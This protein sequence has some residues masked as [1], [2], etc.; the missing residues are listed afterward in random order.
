[1]TQLTHSF[2]TLENQNFFQ[3]RADFELVFTL[4]QTL[5]EGCV[6]L[7]VLIYDGFLFQVLS[8]LK[9]F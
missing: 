7:R 1:M 4:E 8:Q 5:F 9:E 3:R 2:Q 6:L